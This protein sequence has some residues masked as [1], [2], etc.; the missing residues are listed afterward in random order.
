MSQTVL[1]LDDEES[2]LELTA[3]YLR[4]SGYTTLSCT[5]PDAA[6]DSFHETN[7][8]VDLLIADV[9]LRDASGVEAAIH[10]QQLAPG[11]RLLF[12]SGYSADDWKARDAAF[13]ERLS[14]DSVRILRKP[15]SARELLARTAE[16]IG[17]PTK[18]FAGGQEAG[19]QTDATER[20]M[21]ITTLER[22]A[23]LLELAHDAIMVRDLTGKIGYWN[24][25]AEILYGWT[26]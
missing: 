5:S 20:K 21:V 8:Q 22:Q 12:M 23:G 10:L 1:I 25:G 13:I 15:F 7:G 16:L 19:T 9:T 4:D 2:V 11:L 18:A 24:R 26:R 3:L 17:V 6:M 14:P